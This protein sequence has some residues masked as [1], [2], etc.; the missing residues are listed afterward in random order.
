MKREEF[1]GLLRCAAAY[2]ENGWPLTSTW[3]H[4][5]SVSDV[6]SARICRTIG[7]AAWRTSQ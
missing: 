7:K 1:E 6:E 2:M 5:H 3:T 4:C